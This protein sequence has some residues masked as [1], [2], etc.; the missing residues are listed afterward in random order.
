MNK[1]D[2][3][4]QNILIIGISGGLAQ[5]LSRLILENHPDWKITGI[6]SRS[7]DH[8]VEIPGL[9]ILSS[10][11]SRGN[12]EKLFRENVDIPWVGRFVLGRFWRQTNDAQKA[13]YI[14]EY[15]T[16]LVSHYASRFSEYSNGSFKIANSRDDGENEYTITMQLLS[17]DAGAQPV[18]VDYRVRAGEKGFKVFDVIVE[19]VSMITTQ[20]AEFGSVVSDKGIDY[21]ISQLASRKLEMPA[22]KPVTH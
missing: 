11:Y 10:R 6:D 9:T 1:N 22:E 17:G 8:V 12:F 2:N 13:K 5:I 14:K 4:P 15:E 7:T 20:R 18:I 3:K 21:L 19:G 16:F